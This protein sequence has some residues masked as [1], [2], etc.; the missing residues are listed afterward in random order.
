MFDANGRIFLVPDLV[1]AV[2]VEQHRHIQRIARGE[3]EIAAEHRDFGGRGHRV[4]IRLH[5][6]NRALLH[7][8]E[9]LAG[10]DQLVGIEQLDLHAVACDLVE[11]LDRRVDHVSGQCGARIGL[12]APLDRAL[13][14]RRRCQRCRGQSGPGGG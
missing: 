4:I 10:R 2:L 1:Q 6:I 13:R 9:Q 5:R 7:G 3:R 12:H 8:A 11:H 14:N